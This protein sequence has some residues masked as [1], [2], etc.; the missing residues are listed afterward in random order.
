MKISSIIDSANKFQE[1]G[2]GITRTGHPNRNPETLLSETLINILLKE[3]KKTNIFDRLNKEYP[4]IDFKKFIL[5][6]LTPETQELLAKDR[7]KLKSELENSKEITDKNGEIANK[8]LI[9]F[10]NEYYKCEKPERIK[11][12]N[13]VEKALI[14]KLTTIPEGHETYGVRVT[15]IHRID[16]E[17]KMRE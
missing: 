15:S 2:G 4:D 3:N 1:R 11:I 16:V 8:N 14:K 12:V 9:R 10:L 6:D 17:K 7:K 13:E 5:E